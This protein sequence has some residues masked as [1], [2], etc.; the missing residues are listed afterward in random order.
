MGSFPEPKLIPNC[1]RD[2]HS[3]KISHSQESVNPSPKSILWILSD[4]W[5]GNASDYSFR[6]YPGIILFYL[7]NWLHSKVRKNVEL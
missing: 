1:Y 7:V 4:H 6:Y 2:S 5:C 3:E